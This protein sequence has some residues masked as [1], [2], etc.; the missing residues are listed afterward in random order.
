MLRRSLPSHVWR[1]AVNLKDISLICTGDIVRYLENHYNLRVDRN[2]LSRKLRWEMGKRHPVE[3]YCQNLVTNLM[4]Y[5]QLNAGM[6]CEARV[7]RDNG[8]HSAFW[9]F[10]Q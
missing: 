4:G 2:V 7:N 5:T 1:D 8:L 10:P 3:R 6:F 9:G